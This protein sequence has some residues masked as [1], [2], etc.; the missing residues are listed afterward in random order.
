MWTTKS[1]YSIKIQ[2]PSSDPSMPSLC[3]PSFFISASISLAMAWLR[4]RE[5]AVAITKK[6]SRGVARR[7]S[8]STMSLAPLSSAIRAA[9]RAC[10]SARLT[11]SGSLRSMACVGM[12][13]CAVLIDRP[14]MDF[15][16]TEVSETGAG[17]FIG[18]MFS[19]IHRFQESNISRWEDRHVSWFT[20]N[21][22]PDEIDLLDTPGALGFDRPEQEFTRTM[23]V[24]TIAS[25]TRPGGIF[26]RNGRFWIVG[27]A[28]KSS[29]ATQ[30]YYLTNEQ[31]GS[32]TVRVGLH[33]DHSGAER[34]SILRRGFPA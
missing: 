3:S 7:R 4:R 22:R 28:C 21:S 12:S 5:F 6:S 2:R 25:A 17:C 34:R 30:E 13:S 20:N 23:P 24:L 15:D 9:I 8:R 31:H 26:R 10:A 16:R 33:A 27:E 1:P 11:R 19:V 29:I 18:G 14:R 32:V